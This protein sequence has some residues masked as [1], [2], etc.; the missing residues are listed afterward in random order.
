MLLF[1]NHN[2]VAQTAVAPSVGDGSESNPYQIAT[3]ENLYWISQQV[4]GGNAFS[5]KYFSQTQDIN[6]SVT[7]GWDHGQGWISIGTQ[8]SLCFSGYYNGNGHVIENLYINRIYKSN[9]G[10]FGL[11]DGATIR[12]LGLTNVSIN[13][14]NDVGS[15]VGYAVSSH[16]DKSYC[17][18]AVNGGQIAGGLV[19]RLKNGAIHNSYSSVDVTGESFVGGLV[20]LTYRSGVYS[21]YSMGSAS[22]DYRV[23]GLVGYHNEFSVITNSYS[24]GRVSG[25]YQFGG[26][27]GLNGG[28]FVSNSFWDKE[29]SGQNS[30]S[31]GTGKTTTQMKASATFLS[32][33]WDFKDETANGDNDLWTIDEKYK[34]DNNG[35]PAVAW[36]GLE[37][38]FLYKPEGEGTESDPYLISSFGNLEWISIMS[39]FGHTFVDTFFLQTQDIDAS[40]TKSLNKGSGW[41][42]I[43]NSVAQFSGTYNGNSFSID[44]LYIDRPSMDLVGLFGYTQEAGIKNLSLTNVAITGNKHVGALAG[45]LN[46]STI[47]NCLSLGNINGVKSIGGL[48]GISSYSTISSSCSRVSLRSTDDNVGGLVGYSYNST[49]S[50]C[51]STGSVRGV[52]G[53]SNNVGGLVGSNSDSDIF[54]CYSTGSVIGSSFYSGGLIGQ[55]SRESDI[56]SSFWDTQTSGQNSS[57]G[58]TGKTTAQMQSQVTFLSAGWDFKEETANGVEEIWTIDELYKSDNDGYPALSWQ[59]MKNHIL[60]EPDGEGTQSNPYQITTLED[61]YWI[62]QKVNSGHTFVDTFFTQTQDIDASTTNLMNDGKG[63]LPI[64]NDAYKFSGTYSGNH[65]TINGLYINRSSTNYLGLFGHTEGA[66]IENIGLRAVE[67]TGYG[68]IGGLVGINSHSTITNSYA[69]GSLNGSGYYTGGLIGYNRYSTVSNSYSGCKVG[70]LNHVGGFIGYATVSKISNCYNIGSV[71]VTN[72]Y[73]GGFVGY[74]NETDISSSYS[75]GS[76]SGNSN[77]GGFIGFEEGGSTVANSFWDTETSGLET[78]AGGVGKT[79]AK[80]RSLAT[81]TDTDSLGLDLAWDFLDNPNDDAGNDDHW[82]FNNVI[83]G[84]PYLAW[85]RSH[86]AT[87]LSGNTAQHMFPAAGIALQF[88]IGNTSDIELNITR[89]DSMPSIVGS[90]P[91]GVLNL[92]QRYWSAT[93][94]S[95]LADGTYN[96]IIDISG[97]NGIDNCTN[98]NVLKRADSSSAWLDVETLSGTLV[99]D[100]PNTIT[101]IGLTG[102]SDFVIGG[103]SD[104]PL[105]VEL[106]GFS[107]S[108]TSSGIE[109]TWQTQT[110]T[111]NAGFILQRNGVEIAHYQNTDALN[112]QGT[113]SEEHAYTFI[114]AD[115]SLE[116]TYTY[117]LISVDYS[118]IKHSYD[119]TIEVRVTEAIEPQ[120]PYEYA[121]HQNYPNPFNPATIISFMMKKAG[122]ASLKVYDVLGRMVLSKSIEAERGPNVYNFNG[123]NYSSGVYF[124]QLNAE[125]FSKTLKMMLVK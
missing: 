78:S 46:K 88:T 109:L 118:G 9:V 60:T 125:G 68:F 100:C 15:L 47:S 22:G 18:G 42:P 32:A 12:N 65:H 54:K 5:G 98:L 95:G 71:D 90:L 30:S 115:V 108:S 64:G 120:K 94:D 16:I 86:M 27:V 89:I 49:I 61:L 53:T 26:L 35:Y 21:S 56:I 43:G 57:A 87:I 84:Y 117:E 124:Y 1:F 62:S 28:S 4:Q 29:T 66:S 50:D 11:T 69:E 17:T 51:Y 24:A 38:G 59:E 63:W 103:G 3:L 19:G 77:V 10:L 73:A 112:G 45:R 74:N 116:E 39:E 83:T 25:N 96:I 72:N 23:G 122:V 52:P 6:A 55:S 92:S 80:M 79:T 31:G 81:F 7:S 13:A 58:G 123:Q 67:I 44:S 114:D 41:L 119:K 82:G 33:G 104:N 93:V 76:V 70:G 110:E 34:N 14:D 36:Q 121:L 2:S 105:P 113:T 106:A 48:I 107:G 37:N 111:N 97:L 91:S 102:F 20:G 85:Q 40:S 75:V 8:F 101:V 99:Y